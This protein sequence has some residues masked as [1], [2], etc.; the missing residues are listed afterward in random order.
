MT[1]KL[2]TKNIYDAIEQG[3][4]ESLK[5]H[6]EQESYPRDTK[7]KLFVVCVQSGHL[8]LVKFMH[9]EKIADINF[10]EHPVGLSEALIAEH[11]DIIDYFLKQGANLDK[12]CDMAQCSV[13]T[14]NIQTVDHLRNI[15]T[16][17][18]CDFRSEDINCFMR[19]AASQNNVPMVHYLVEYQGHTP[20]TPEAEKKDILE[21]ARINKKSEIIEYFA[22]LD[23]VESIARGDLECPARPEFQTIDDLHIERVN[24]DAKGMSGS[25]FAAMAL[26]RR[27]S[28]VM[29][30]HRS[31]D[32]RLLTTQDLKKWGLLS[33][34]N[35]H[36]LSLTG[37]LKTIFNAQYWPLKN[38]NVIEHFDNLFNG[39]SPENQKH[40]QADYKIARTEMQIAN[41]SASRP[42]PRLKR[43]IKQKGRTL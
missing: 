37:Q 38:P 19:S 15:L 18:G 8:P 21:K 16:R 41:I 4:L 20:Y 35:E 40:V 30:C 1:V 31:Q 29:Q 39:L 24:Y 25:G 2:V 5:Q 22:D 34:P 11:Y 36:L 28:D 43:R 6:L 3:D 42:A 23:T 14:G 12:V 9:E 17:Y 32:G 13:M 33:M 26:S 10:P 27:F 7:D